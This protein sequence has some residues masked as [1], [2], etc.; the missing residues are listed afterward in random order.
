MISIGKKPATCPSDKAPASEARYVNRQFNIASKICVQVCPPSVPTVRTAPTDR[1]FSRPLRRLRPPVRR[2][3]A[4]P[5]L[6]SRR[7]GRRRGGQSRSRKGGGVGKEGGRR[8]GG[9][10][11]NTGG[12]VP[13][14][15][16]RHRGA[17]G[18]EGGEILQQGFAF[19]GGV[20]VSPPSTVRWTP[21]RPPGDGR[22]GAQHR[23]AAG[24]VAAA[25]AAR[26]DPPGCGRGFV[27][28][29]L[30]LSRSAFTV[31]K[32]APADADGRAGRVCESSDQSSAV[33]RQTLR[34]QEGHRGAPA[35][36]NP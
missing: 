7:G 22:G 28:R 21:L 29:R 1:P 5:S 2:P 34:F 17:G 36:T 4:H 23:E 13:Q 19:D 35:F 8:R 31:Q 3:A 6:G 20:G 12:E 32:P 11:R 26:E 15:P 25:A 18:C 27:E 9:G 16:D 24:R 33:P 30:R 10:R 14:E